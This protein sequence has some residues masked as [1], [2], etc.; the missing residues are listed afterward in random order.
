[1]GDDLLAKERAPAA[2][3]QAQ[4]PVQLVGAVD[5]DVED[6][7]FVEGAHRNAKLAAK[8][9]RALGGGDARHL[10]PGA[11]MLAENA[12][13]GLGCRAGSYPEIDPLFEIGKGRFGRLTLECRSVRHR[14]PPWP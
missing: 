7:Q 12:D 13:E 14:E 3:D 5:G 4:L 2:L 10:E 11:H 6:R 8:T 9:I 1:M